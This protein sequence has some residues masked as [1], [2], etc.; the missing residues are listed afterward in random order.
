MGACTS[1]MATFIENPKNLTIII[2][3]FLIALVLF[4]V[5]V[6]KALSTKQKLAVIYAHIFFL[7]FPVIYYFF[8]RGCQS[9]FSQC[10]KTK[11]VF[12]MLLLTALLASVLVSV[13]APFLF[14]NR[15]TRKSSVATLENAGA[16]VNFVRKYSN[17]L[18][19]KTPKI[20]VLDSQ[21][22]EAFSFNLFKGKIFIS[23]GMIEL[24]SKKELHA[25]LLHELGHIKNNS[26]V[27]KFSFM[28]FKRLSPLAMFGSTRIANQLDEHECNADSVVLEYQKKAKHLVNAKMKVEEFGKFN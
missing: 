27:L 24:L 9:F 3:S 13:I 1:C 18:A 2:S 14:L 22:P 21:K 12:I 8:F 11:A 26:S 19:I 6:R 20:Y 23:L 28:L 10:E 25:V 15:Y 17:K 16:I 5:L 7:V 4:I